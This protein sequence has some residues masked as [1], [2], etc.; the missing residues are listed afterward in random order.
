MTKQMEQ[1]QGAANTN[2]YQH[3]AY[4][5]ARGRY[6]EFGGR[7]VPESLMAALD[8]LESAYMTAIGDP[9]FSAELAQ[10]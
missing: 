9:A 6:G 2:V 5:D 8:E 10:Q 4:P 1:I 7:F 3:G